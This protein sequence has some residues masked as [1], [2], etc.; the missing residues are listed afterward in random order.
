MSRRLCE[1][2]PEFVAL[3]WFGSINQPVS[4][5]FSIA[6]DP[7]FLKLVSGKLRVPHAEKLVEGTI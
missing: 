5:G 1:S 2:E 7:L 3:A 6:Y 4:Q